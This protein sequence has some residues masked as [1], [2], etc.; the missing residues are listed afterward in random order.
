MEPSDEKDFIYYVTQFWSFLAVGLVVYIGGLSTKRLMRL[1]VK[2]GTPEEERPTW[3]R[4]WDDTQRWQIVLLAS[5][6]GFVPSI[7]VAV[8]VPDITVARMMWFAF[9]GA[10]CGHLYAAI[11]D[12]GKSFPDM[13]RSF[14][15]Q[16][17]GFTMGS[18][19]ASVAEK[20]LPAETDADDRGSEP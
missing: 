7:P 8:W 14:L 11:K 15:Q 19:S 12:L 10:V 18:G 13:V 5:C 16:R 20:S 4:V 1:I 2:P 9:A 3:Y 6:F 17:F